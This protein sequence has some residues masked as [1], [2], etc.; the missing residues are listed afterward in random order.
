MDNVEEF[1]EFVRADPAVARESS[2]H[3]PRKQAHVH[4]HHPMESDSL[5]FTTLR[6][7]VR[8]GRLF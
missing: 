6:G 1:A 7:A 4:V 5:S 2:V 8:Q 3:L